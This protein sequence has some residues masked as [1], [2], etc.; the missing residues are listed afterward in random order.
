LKLPRRLPLLATAVL[1]GCG[2]SSGGNAGPGDPP[3]LGNGTTVQVAVR[4]R[5]NAYRVQQSSAVYQGRLQT[6]LSRPGLPPVS[7]LLTDPS[8]ARQ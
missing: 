1:A 3:G 7:Q 4:N 5:I 2:S 8:R 6:P